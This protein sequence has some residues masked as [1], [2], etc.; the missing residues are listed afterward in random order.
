MSGS[1]RGEAVNAGFKEGERWEFARYAMDRLAKLS[2]RVGDITFARPVPGLVYR[3]R[4]SAISVRLVKALGRLARV[5]F[6]CSSIWGHGK[7]REASKRSFRRAL[8][9][10][11]PALFSRLRV[12]QGRTGGPLKDITL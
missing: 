12:E 3:L 7:S 9:V 5:A 1:T 4:A 8:L 2:A 10:R 11:A 6:R